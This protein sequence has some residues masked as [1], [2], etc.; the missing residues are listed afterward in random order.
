M[1][2]FKQA[3]QTN[4]YLEM[5]ILDIRDIS[6]LYGLLLTK[7][8]K[9]TTDEEIFNEFLA[10]SLVA[11]SHILAKLEGSGEKATTLLK[12]FEEFQPWLDDISI[13]KLNIEETKK[14]H[15]LFRL[16]LKSYDLLGI[17]NI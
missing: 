12:E 9:I 4:L 11:V 10:Y 16:I 1:A 13:P 17:S 14:I 15:K 7:Y 2:E 6:K 3:E 5:L 8:A